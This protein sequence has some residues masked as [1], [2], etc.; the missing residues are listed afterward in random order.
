MD[1]LEGINKNTDEIQCC[2]S[3]LIALEEKLAKLAERVDRLEQGSSR[4]VCSAE[5]LTKREEEVFLVLYL[6]DEPLTI[7][8]IARRLGVAE[9]VVEQVVESLSFKGI[10]LIRQYRNQEVFVSLDLKFK[11]L[12]AKQNVLKIQRG[13]AQQVLPV[14]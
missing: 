3:F 6:H 5:R 1:H 7:R 13:I 12:Q 10:P 4:G 2:Y 9:E 14:E 11:E 8:H